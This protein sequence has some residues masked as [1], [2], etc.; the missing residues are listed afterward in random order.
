MREIVGTMAQEI[1]ILKAQIKKLS[2]PA[3]NNI[4]NEN[5]IKRMDD[6]I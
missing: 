2:T 3:E 1:S 4:R 5:D 6:N